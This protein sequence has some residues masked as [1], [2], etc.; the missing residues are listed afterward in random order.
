MLAHIYSIYI[1]IYICL[2]LDCHVPENSFH[3]GYVIVSKGN[4]I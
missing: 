2:F 4:Q 3:L 1:Y